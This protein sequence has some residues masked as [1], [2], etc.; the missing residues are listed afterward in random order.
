MFILQFKISTESTYFKTEQF[1]LARMQE[2]QTLILY[3]LS[4]VLNPNKSNY[5]ARFNLIYNLTPPII[6][7]TF[8]FSLID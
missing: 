7:H 4:T 3:L 2:P 5:L 8:S 1:I 6:T